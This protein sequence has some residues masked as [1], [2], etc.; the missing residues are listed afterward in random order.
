VQV[1][2]ITSKCLGNISITLPWPAWCVR[3]LLRISFRSTANWDGLYDTRRVV[4]AVTV[5]RTVAGWGLNECPADGRVVARGSLGYLAHIYGNVH[6]GGGGGGGGPSSPVHHPVPLPP[7]IVG[8]ESCPWTIIVH[9]GQTVSLRVIV[10]PAETL[11]GSALS[12][13][14]GKGVSVATSLS[15][16][17]PGCLT[18]F[19]IREPVE[20]S[21]P[22]TSSNRH[23]PQFNV[24][25]GS[26]GG[27]SR[28]RHLYTSTGNSVTIHVTS[29]R[30]SSV[31]NSGQPQGG[32]SS[33]GDT[34][35]V[36]TRFIISYEGDSL[37][38]LFIS[39]RQFHSDSI[40]FNFFWRGLISSLTV[41]IVYQVLQ[42]LDEQKGRGREP[43]R[44][45]TF[46]KLNRL[47]RNMI[48]SNRLV[49]YMN[50]KFVEPVGNPW[51]FN[52]ILKRLNINIVHSHSREVTHLW[53]N[54][55]RLKL[56]CQCVQRCITS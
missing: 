55:L 18:A 9:P 8:T 53:A 24:C 49:D 2:A 27:K 45:S 46:E 56:I 37:L 44:A 20:V 30:M 32:S 29:T 33:T 26:V 11:T 34:A 42:Q 22:A 6:A 43:W 10:L 17:T 47:N 23:R 5:F 48:T 3:L 28:E 36:A 38:W 35:S 50:I 7:R 40:Q 21:S 13:A 39:S 54:L 14:A 31:T 12:R 16:S 15:D 51:R 25:T 52:A 19:V 41:S 1:A 4:N